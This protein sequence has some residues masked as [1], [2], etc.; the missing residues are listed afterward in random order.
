MSNYINALNNVK[1]F[2]EVMFDKDGDEYNCGSLYQIGNLLGFGEEVEELQKLIEK[3]TMIRLQIT[4]A[5]FMDTDGKLKVLDNIERIINGK[6][7]EWE[8]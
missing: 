7:G 8:C 4:N 5:K 1:D 2:E 6:G 3:Q